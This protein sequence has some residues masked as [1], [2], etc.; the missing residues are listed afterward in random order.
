MREITMI[1]APLVLGYLLDLWLGDPRGLPHPIVGYGRLIAIAEARLNRGEGRLWKGGLMAVGLV[2][3]TAYIWWALEYLAGMWLVEAAMAVACAGVFFGLANR[4]LIAE[5]QG[6]FAALDQSLAAGRE[7]LSRIV[8]RD[9]SDLDEQQVR[10]AVAETMSEN[11]SDG[12]VA[13]LFYFGLGGVPAMMAYK[14]INTMDSMVGYRNARYERFGKV[15]ARWDDVA[16]FLPARITALLMVIVSGSGRAARYAWRYGR[17]HSS[18]NAG[19][20]EAALAGILRVR[21]GGPHHYKGQLVKKPWI[22][23]AGRDLEA[24]DITRITRLNHGVCALMVG[25]AGLMRWKLSG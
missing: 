4:T 19:Y 10:T 11:L 9:T 22:G 16:N 7:R 3:G 25:V 14:M 2:V 6:V 13:P 8:G 15:A 1:L 18:P 5:G 17:A 24:Q 12:V 23:E 20:P 21:F